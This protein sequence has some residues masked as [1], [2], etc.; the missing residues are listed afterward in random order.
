MC[1][2]A[3]GVVQVEQSTGA[4]WASVV[5]AGWIDVECLASV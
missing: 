5:V 1:G 2:R 3:E 4:E